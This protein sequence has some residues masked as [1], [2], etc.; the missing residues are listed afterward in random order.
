MLDTLELELLKMDNKVRFILDVVKGN[1]IVNN[2][3][4]AEL[5]HELKEKGFTPFPKKTKAVEVA[6]AGDIDHEGEPEL[7]PEATT[8]SDYDYLLSMA[9]GTLTL[10][11]VQELCSDRDKLEH[12]VE[13][14]R[15]HTPKFLWLKDLEALEKLLDVCTKN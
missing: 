4:R 6:V 8:A 9:I 7:S 1:I 5:F 2:R 3:K 10:E 13:E 14:L 15:K 12:E 11:K